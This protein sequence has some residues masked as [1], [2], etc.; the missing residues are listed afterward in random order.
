MK[1]HS[2][3][4]DDRG[5]IMI[6]ALCFAVFGVAILYLAVGAAESVLFREHLQD[7]ADSA[8]LSAAASGNRFTSRQGGPFRPIPQ[9]RVDLRAGG[10]NRTRNLPLTRRLLC[11]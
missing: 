1:C 2:A 4:S 6:I 10:G 7:A 11:H 8:A 3:I 9:L 5:A